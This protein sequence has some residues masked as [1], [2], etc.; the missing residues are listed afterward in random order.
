MM[1]DEWILRSREQVEMEVINDPTGEID[2]QDAEFPWWYS[3]QR[4]RC[5]FE[6]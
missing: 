1:N 6:K 4:S 5:S 2:R 3:I